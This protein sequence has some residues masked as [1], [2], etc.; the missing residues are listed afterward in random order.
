MTD[1]PSARTRRARALLAALGLARRRGVNG[2]ELA[3]MPS[4]LSR[5][6]VA[7]RAR[8]RRRSYRQ[9]GCLLNSQA[10]G[11]DSLLLLRPPSSTVIEFQSAGEQRREPISIGLGP[12]GFKAF[13]FRRWLDCPSPQAS[14]SGGSRALLLPWVRGN[15][16]PWGPPKLHVAIRLWTRKRAR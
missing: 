15:S 16:L 11:L 5:G 3:E 14:P 13:T 10:P 12:G 1:Q 7:A 2:R 4:I 8:L 9:P 6:C